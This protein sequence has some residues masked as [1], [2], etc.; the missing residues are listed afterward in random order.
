MDT[1]D[2]PSGRTTQ[3]PLGGRGPGE[4]RSRAYPPRYASDIVLRDGSTIRLRPLSPQDENGLVALHRRLSDQ[5]AHFRFFGPAA[6][7]TVERLRELCRAALPDSFGLAGELRGRVV[8]VAHWFR[9]PASANQA[10]VAFVTDEALR[11]RGIGT[12][13]L[14]RLADIAREHGI[15]RF[16]AEVQ[17]ANH[18][19]ID[20]FLKSGFEVE[21]RGE[22]GVLHLG[23]SIAPTPSF[24]E[25]AAERSRLA[26]SASMKRFFAPSSIAVVGAGP[27]RGRLGAEIFHNLQS[28]GYQGV[29]YAIHPTARVVG[30][31]RAHARVS[32]LPEPVDL[33]IVVVPAD[34]VDEVVDDC[35]AAG[36]GAVVVITAGFAETGAEGRAREAAMVARL[37]EAGVRM[38]GPNCMGI[39]NTHPSV[40]MN[41]T[42]A[43]IHAPA[44]RVGIATQSGALGVAIVE[45]AQRKGIGLSTFV[46]LGNKADVSGNDL[47]QYWCEDDDTDVIALYLESFGNPRRFGQIARHVARRKP[48]V[49]VKS[50]RSKAGAR[51]ASSHSGALASADTAVEALFRHAGVIRT[52]TIEEMFDVTAV[53]SSQPTPVGR[54][55]AVLTNAGGPA[56]LAA[57]SLEANGLVLP[58][59]SD[60][61]VAELR[62][63]LPAAASVANPVDMIASADGPQ[64][65]R[66]LRALLRDDQVDSVIVIYVPVFPTDLPVVAD[67]VMRAAAEC[68]HK[69][70]LTSFM[71]EDGGLIRLPRFLFP[72]SA[73]RAL[74]RVTRYGEWLRK[75]LGTVPT[76]DGLDLAR[77]RAVVQAALDRGGHW[78]DPR[79][80]SDLFDAVGIP[81]P[82]TRMT[83]TV[84][85]AVAAADAVGYPVVVKAVGPSILHKTE[86]GAVA[87]RLRDADAVRAAWLAMEARLGDHMSGAQVQEMVEGGVEVVVGAFVDPTFGPLVVYGSGGILVELL[88]D[89][90]FRMP[91]LTDRDVDE[92]LDEVKGTALLRGYRG[93][94][95]ADESAVRSI[96]YRMGQLLTA[97]PEIQ[98]V[99]LNPIKVLGSGAR[100]VDARVRVGRPAEPASTRRIVY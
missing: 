98:E 99:D 78:L 46:S 16:E 11:G 90:S 74:A 10:E 58:S 38:I 42:F 34:N 76:L 100:A 32:A 84:D 36:T 15:D 88:A 19:M 17:G 39:I 40:R 97:C 51:A 43:S 49:A 71:H 77:A 82:G 3:A 55:V 68:N 94:P 59:L 65:E 79:E 81:V 20:V 45:H 61:T 2:T 28:D 87:L 30:S 93:A 60:A 75:P 91:P 13:M 29:L 37:R 52:D 48:I 70:I 56:I 12:R 9:S 57:D 27:T 67:H 72:E 6:A 33:A 47:L 50:G 95:T 86:M 41:G 14:E 31:T 62:S 22:L 83:A 35:I 21:R 24:E 5:D 63:F 1:T 54:R 64:Y 85:E 89:A 92:M 26:A 7:V 25:K 8:A 96:L 4:A 66:A 44:G 53:L 80:L 18:S 23:F 69:P 73:A